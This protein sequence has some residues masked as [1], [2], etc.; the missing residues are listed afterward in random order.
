[1]VYSCTATF[2]YKGV[3]GQ[4]PLF[5]LDGRIQGIRSVEHAKFIAEEIC[6]PAKIKG[7]KVNVMVIEADREV[8][9][10]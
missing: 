6:N 7:L 4:I 9:A 2:E 8:W 1:M 5:I 3:S 10:A